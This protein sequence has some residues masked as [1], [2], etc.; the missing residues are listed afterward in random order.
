MNDR[1]RMKATSFLLLFALMGLRAEAQVAYAGPDTSLCVNFYTMQGSPL[2]LGA[3]GVWTTI[4]G[5]GTIVD[6]TT[7]TTQVVNICIGSNVFE[8]T[9]DDGGNLTSDDVVITVYDGSMAFASAGMDQTIIGP[10]DYAYLNGSPVPI[11]P[12]TC[13]WSIVAGTGNI[14]D[15]WDPFT[16]VSGLTFGDNIYC[17]TCYNGPCGT[18]TDTVNVQMMMMTGLD[19]DEGSTAPVLHF[20]PTTEQL[21]YTGSARVDALAV[22]DMQG[23]TVPASRSRHGS[24]QMSRMLPGLYIAQIIVEEVPMSYRFVM[25]H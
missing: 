8:W 22:F 11:Y 20:D 13:L 5:C 10:Q 9:V 23:R 4:A 16:A 14:V 7:P 2:P 1:A 3:T 6:A 17:W 21:R 19:E 12:A 24:W 15:P 18:S 25:S